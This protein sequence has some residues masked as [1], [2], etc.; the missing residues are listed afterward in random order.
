MNQNTNPGTAAVT[1]TPPQPTTPPVVPFAPAPV[2]MMSIAKNTFHAILG[3][4]IGASVLLVFVLGVLG[5]GGRLGHT[6]S[7]TAPT[8]APVAAVVAQHGPSAHTLAVLAQTRAQS[9]TPCWAEWNET[10]AP[11][12]TQNVKG[13]DGYPLDGFEIVCGA[14]TK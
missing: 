12:A 2:V 10:Q 14:T 5:A 9:P 4:A 7:T 6:T 1:T 3:V 11:L 8:L 13:L